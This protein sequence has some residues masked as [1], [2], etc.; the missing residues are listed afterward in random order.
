[1]STTNVLS[2]QSLAVYAVHTPNPTLQHCVQTQEMPIDKFCILSFK[3]GSREQRAAD[4]MTGTSERGKFLEIK[5]LT[6]G[7]KSKRNLG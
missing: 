7:Q 3:G 6:D 2:L 4:Q 5:K 1:M